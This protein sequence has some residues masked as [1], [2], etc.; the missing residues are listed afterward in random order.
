MYTVKPVVDYLS[1][2]NVNHIRCKN[3][4]HLLG[5]FLFERWTESKWSYCN[6][7]MFIGETVALDK[8]LGKDKFARR[9][10]QYIFVVCSFI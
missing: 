10:Q 7:K 4:L 6:F 3:I 5:E 9:R 1:I 2:V 8:T